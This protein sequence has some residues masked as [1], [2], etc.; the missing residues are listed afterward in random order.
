M[1]S[2]ALDREALARRNQRVAQ[3]L[4]QP[5]LRHRFRNGFLRLIAK[6]P[7]S[8]QRGKSNRILIIRPDHLGDMLLTTPAIKAIKAQRPELSIHVL[9]GDW[10]ADILANFEE[11]D[12][13]LTLPFPGF[14]REAAGGGNPYLLA[15]QSARKL[16]RVGY[17]SAIIMRP[18]HWWGALLAFLAGIQER[19]GYDAPG[20][21]PFL[22]A[23]LRLE[24]Q[25]VVEQNL[26]LAGTF[27]DIPRGDAVRLDFPLQSVDCDR[28]DARL[29]DLGIPAGAPIIC[30]HPGSGASSKL[31]RA[32]K[33]G[34]V[35]DALAQEHSAAI[36]FTGTAGEKAIIEGIAGKMKAGSSIIAGSTSVGELAALY[37]RALIVLGPDSGAM[38]I[39]AAVHRPTVALF[40]PADPI[41]F[42]PWGDPRRQAVVTSDIACRPCRILDWREDDR[43]WHP[44]VR[45]ISVGQVLAAARRVLGDG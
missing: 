31:W 2:W 42:A 26:R 10:C 8:P 1:R 7:V 44:C 37:R 6:A 25:H 29:S 40:G 16:R 45:D 14:R 20:A 39:A 4:H 18:D 24:H 15:L 30:I 21:A 35:A 12:R 36:V 17:D 43:D 3:A 23:A 27:A 38:H 28:I 32:D 11:V 22:T 19:I 5:S 41:E 13:V 34:T 33:W 9:C